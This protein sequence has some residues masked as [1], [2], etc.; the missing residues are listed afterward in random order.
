M[1]KAVIIGIIVVM[2]IVLGCVAFFFWP[3]TEAYNDGTI[4]KCEFKNL[5][6]G[7]GYGLTLE[8]GENEL[9]IGISSGE[10]KVRITG[11]GKEL[12]S[13][14]LSGESSK[15]LKVDIPSDGIYMLFIDG[16]RASGTINYPVANTEQIGDDEQLNDKPESSEVRANQ[17]Q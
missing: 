10:V 15:T 8:K 16:K 14:E 4:G 11:E 17:T 2:I 1:K 13:E 3:K 5:R 12:V 7:I 6:G 9:T